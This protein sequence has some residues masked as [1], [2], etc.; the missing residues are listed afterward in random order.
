[1]D[2]GQTSTASSGVIA[3]ARTRTSKQDVHAQEQRIN[4]T[5]IPWCI[6][7]VEFRTCAYPVDD[8]V[9]FIVRNSLIVLQERSRYIQSSPSLKLG[10]S[11]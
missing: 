5:S 2:G 6:P 4:S 10:S 11:C 3:F 1:M 9:E 8:R 7:M